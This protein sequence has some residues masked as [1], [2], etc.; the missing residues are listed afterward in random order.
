MLHCLDCYVS[1]FYRTLKS[2]LLLF[3][4]HCGIMARPMIIGGSPS[5]SGQWP[6]QVSLQITAAVEPWHRCGGVLIHASW[7]LTAAHCV[8]G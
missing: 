8:E 3:I 4:E 2:L 1:M 7:V 6:W 5:K